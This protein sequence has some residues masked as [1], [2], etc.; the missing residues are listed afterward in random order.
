MTSSPSVH[1]CQ[2]AGCTR[3]CV[4]WLCMAH[5]TLQA[6]MAPEHQPARE[7]AA[8]A[9]LASPGPAADALDP[10]G[11]VQMF[12]GVASRNLPASLADNAR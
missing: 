2:H 9:V 3:L 1:R 6:E 5:S 8:C 7:N 11:V 4:G 12:E 10:G